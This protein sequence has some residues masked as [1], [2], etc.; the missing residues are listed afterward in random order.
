MI[1]FDLG[2]IMTHMNTPEISSRAVLKHLGATC[3][4]TQTGLK[5]KDLAADL[6]V[7]RATLNGWLQQFNENGLLTYESTDKRVW[8]SF[9]EEGKKNSGGSTSHISNCFVGNHRL[10]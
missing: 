5:K 1:I 7:S 9:T 4:N 6:D 3:W 10:N 8:I 2:L